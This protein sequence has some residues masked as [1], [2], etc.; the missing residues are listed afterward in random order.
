MVDGEGTDAFYI[1]DSKEDAIRKHIKRCAELYFISFNRK[2]DMKIFDGIDAR[3]FIVA[4][5]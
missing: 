4:H 1:A 3:K 5:E 2:P